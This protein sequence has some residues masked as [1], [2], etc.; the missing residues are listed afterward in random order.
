MFDIDKAKRTD[1]KI[2]RWF[3]M[4]L[5]IYIIHNLVDIN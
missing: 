2:Y 4:N 1:K 5:I 3:K